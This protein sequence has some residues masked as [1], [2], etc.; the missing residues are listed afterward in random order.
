MSHKPSGVVQIPGEHLV[1]HY[2]HTLCEC[3]IREESTES[4]IRDLVDDM[5]SDYQYDDVKREYLLQA[6]MKAHG[7]KTSH[8]FMGALSVAPGK[9]KLGLVFIPMFESQDKDV[10]NIVFME[11]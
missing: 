9:E 11:K 10:L 2:M 1:M 4:H 8:T 5:S 7:L 6:L 3:L